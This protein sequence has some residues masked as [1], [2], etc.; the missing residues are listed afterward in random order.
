VR[1][2]CEYEVTV[3]QYPQECG[4]GD[5][6]TYGKGLNEHGHVVGFYWCPTWDD[7][8]SFLW[9][10]EDGFVRLERPPGVVSALATDINDH[11]VICGE[12]I[13]DGVGQRGFVYENDVWTEL[14]TVTGAGFSWASA[15]ANNGAVVGGRAIAND[16]APYNAFI[17]TAAD[18]FI[19]LGVMIGPYSKA[20]DVNDAR[21]VVGVTGPQT[22]PERRA[23]VWDDGELVVLGPV[24][25]GL[26]SGAGSIN[27]RG[28]IAGGGLV[29]PK[30]DPNGAAFVW[31]GRF[32]MLGT[33]PDHASSGTFDISD[34][35]NVVG[36]SYDVGGNTNIE[37]AF[38]W[39][40]G[41]MAD[42]NTLTNLPGLT[43]ERAV[44]INE[45]GQILVRTYDS[46]V[47]LTPIDPPLGDLN[48]DCRV[49]TAD[50][51]MLLGEWGA[52]S[53]SADLND[54]GTVDQLDLQLLLENWG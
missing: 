33:L 26:S 1:A 2:Q 50:L 20:L 8:E 5:V 47:L 21:T 45:A 11:G 14:G 32:T 39:Q 48:I 23:F 6:L 30:N 37:H 52:A 10:S 17:W 29:P 41:V 49:S 9:T 13:V 34:L 43:L 27:K 16:T 51:F 31:N 46:T 28:V 35:G 15:I 44:A 54:D 4:F 3:L 25:G 22:G 12:M 36:R 7:Y 53:S 24:P 18:G 19:D 42:L 38:I 40:N